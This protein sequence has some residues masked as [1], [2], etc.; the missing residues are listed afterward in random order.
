MDD[1]PINTNSLNR[2]ENVLPCKKKS[3]LDLSRKV[4]HNE[5]I[6]NKLFNFTTPSFLKIILKEQF[7]ISIWEDIDQRTVNLNNLMYMFVY[8]FMS[9]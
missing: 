1:N 2:F 9:L 7:E 8:I 5:Q 6:I 4:L 3:T